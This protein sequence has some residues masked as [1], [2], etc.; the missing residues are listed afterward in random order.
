MAQRRILSVDT[1]FDSTLR[2]IALARQRFYDRKISVTYEIRQLGEH[3]ANRDNLLKLCKLK[4]D[5]NDDQSPN[6][7]DA[8]VVSSHGIEG[9]VQDNED[10]PDGILFS[11]NDSNEMIGTIA[12]DRMVYLFSCR[13]ANSNLPQRLID[14]G[15]SMFVGFKDSPVWDSDEGMDFWLGIDLA[16]VEC[17]I[18]NRRTT[19]FWR[20]REDFLERIEDDRPYAP[21]IYRMD[22][23]RIRESLANMVVIEP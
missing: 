8:L 4:L 10:S 21:P 14:A 7:F 1:A 19:A 17:V 13:T 3:N 12:K 18:R 22:L 6:Y 2:K 16:F 23:D 9:V 5:P 20:L 15:A 11:E